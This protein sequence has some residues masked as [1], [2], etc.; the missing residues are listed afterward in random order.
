MIPYGTYKIIHYLGIFVL[1]TALAARLGRSAVSASAGSRSDG[2][3]ALTDTPERRPT[4]DPWARR[5]GILH[6]LAL[7]LV[8]L[9]GFG[10][11]AR[12]DVTHQLGLLPGWVWAKLVLWTGLGAA[13]LVASRSAAWSARLLVAVPVLAVLAGFIAL[14]KPF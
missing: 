9:G 11:L 13:I 3:A 5:L 4:P 10:M 7:F 2:E 6:G 1:L 8:L 12:L 14:T